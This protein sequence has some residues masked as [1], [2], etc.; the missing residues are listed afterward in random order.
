MNLD[1]ND[2]NC[3]VSKYFT[4]KECLWLPSWNRMANDSDGLTPQIKANLIALCGKLDIVRDYLNC[5]IN[6]H[7]MY[8]SPKYSELVGGFST[9]VHTGNGGVAVD[10]DCN[11]NL[12][13]DEIKNLLLPCI[14]NWSLRMEDNGAGASWI[15]LDNHAVIHNRFFKV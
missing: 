2:P 7:C 11:P 15:H 6:V 8:R 4:V 10:F 1:W 3:K 14:E 9:D 12:S 5:P 13:C